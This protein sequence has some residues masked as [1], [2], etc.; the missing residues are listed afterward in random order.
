MATQQNRNINLEDLPLL[1]PSA[2]KIVE[3]IDKNGFG[4]SEEILEHTGMATRT[5]RQAIKILVE[6]DIVKKEPILEDMRR[7]RYVFETEFFYGGLK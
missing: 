7:T 3:Y 5:L 1:P 2:K 4:T 6:H